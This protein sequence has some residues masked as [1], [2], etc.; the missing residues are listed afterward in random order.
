MF[1][2]VNEVLR[3]AA[4]ENHD[5]LLCG[6]Y[7]YG[8]LCSVSVIG[9]WKEMGGTLVEGFELASMQGEDLTV[10]L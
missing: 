2:A 4:V 1:R 8:V 7:V 3:G 10:F 6:P 5:V 9:F